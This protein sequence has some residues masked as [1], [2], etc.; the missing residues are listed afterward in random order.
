[1]PVTKIIRWRLT[2][3]PG[4]MGITGRISR[5]WQGPKENFVST[6]RIK[7]LRWDYLRGRL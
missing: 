5:S 3:E 7:G 4:S 6:K 2:V 1:M